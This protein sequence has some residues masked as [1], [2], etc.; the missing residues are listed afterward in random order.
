MPISSCARRSESAS[1]RSSSETADDD[2]EIAVVR[3]HRRGQEPHGLVLELW[4]HDALHDLRVVRRLLALVGGQEGL[5]PDLGR[6]PEHPPALVDDLR[7]ALV[8]IG[9]AVLL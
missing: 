7:E 5:V 6:G 2:D 1:S 3:L 4:E 8:R 9:Q